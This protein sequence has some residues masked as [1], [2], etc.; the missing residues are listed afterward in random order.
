MV[1]ILTNTHKKKYIFFITYH[2]LLL[3]F[4]IVTNS[5]KW[6]NLT[7]QILLLEAPL[8]IRYA[9]SEGLCETMQ[10]GS[11][12]STVTGCMHNIKV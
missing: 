6:Q 9:N 7:Y 12:I 1:A 5:F 2:P 4:L 3:G 11:P 10:T 8:Y